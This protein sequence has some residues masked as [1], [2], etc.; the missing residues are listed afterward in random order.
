MQKP[1]NMRLLNAKLLSAQ[2]RFDAALPD[3]EP[4]PC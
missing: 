3:L 1:L 2:R 4:A